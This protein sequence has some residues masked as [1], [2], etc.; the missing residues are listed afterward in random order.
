MDNDNNLIKDG[1][2]SPHELKEQG[3][4]TFKPYIPKNV[5][6]YDPIPGKD[7]KEKIIWLCSKL[8]WRNHRIAELLEISPRQV[9]NIRKKLPY[10]KE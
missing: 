1:R 7:A 9:R 10:C 2:F 8:G 3:C 6:Y 5:E 4:R